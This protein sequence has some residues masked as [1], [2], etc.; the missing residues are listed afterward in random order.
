MAAYGRGGRRVEEDASGFRE[1]AWR[2]IEI[3]RM[4]GVPSSKTVRFSG[5]PAVVLALL[6]CFLWFA[7]GQVR[8]KR[9]LP[10]GHRVLAFV[11]KPDMHSRPHG[12][13]AFASQ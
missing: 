6:A 11:R 2:S 1:V 3:G 4:T 5:F 9:T 10:T 8:A 7:C 12:D 13:A